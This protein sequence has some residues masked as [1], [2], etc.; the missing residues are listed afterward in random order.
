MQNPVNLHA[1]LCALK[2]VRCHVHAFKH[3]T[4]R[5]W[6]VWH[7]TAA[8]TRKHTI[9]ETLELTNSNQENKKLGASESG[10]HID[11]ISMVW[12]RSRKRGNES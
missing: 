5:H 6:L 8:P 1:K 7:E 12:N 9:T 4:G 10:I 11:K 2:D 3:V